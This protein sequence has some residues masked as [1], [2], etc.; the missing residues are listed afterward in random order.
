MMESHKGSPV[1]W[2]SRVKWIERRLQQLDRHIAEA[3]DTQDF[4]AVSAFDWKVQ[5]LEREL[6]NLIWQW[7]RLRR[8]PD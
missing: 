5:V 3:K 4:E 8:L 6:H 2:I 1:Q 7:V